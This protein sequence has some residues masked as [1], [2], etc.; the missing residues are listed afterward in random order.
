MHDVL[1]CNPLAVLVQI[2]FDA[3]PGFVLATPDLE[4]EARMRVIEA[5][6]AYEQEMIDNRSNTT[7]I[8]DLN[9][10]N[11][12]TVL[13]EEEMLSQEFRPCRMQWGSENLTAIFSNSL[14][15]CQGSRMLVYFNESEGYKERTLIVV[16]LVTEIARACTYGP[17]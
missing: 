2:T 16:D 17:N 15:V 12:T 6:M 9:L 3:P 11:W 14:V 8:S 4:A 1:V 10:T 13:L 7:N 5:G